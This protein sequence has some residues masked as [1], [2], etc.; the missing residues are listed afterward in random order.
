MNACRYKILFF[1][2]RLNRV[3]LIPQI[4]ASASR[5]SLVS[6]FEASTNSRQPNPSMTLL[7][8]KPERPL[9]PS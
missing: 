3:G 4:H 6:L 5:L 8:T 7:P 2:L 9:S 1:Q